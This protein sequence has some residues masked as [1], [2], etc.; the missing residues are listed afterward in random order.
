[1]QDTQAGLL[2]W[3]LFSIAHYVRATYIIIF[4]IQQNGFQICI[5]LNF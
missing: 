5:Y 1:M 2:E 3:K 4:I